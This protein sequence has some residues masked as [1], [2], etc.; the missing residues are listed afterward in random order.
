LPSGREV[1]DCG[2]SDVIDLSSVANGEWLGWV[3]EMRSMG[4]RNNG[5]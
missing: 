5:M 2:V 1:D 4:E 3:R